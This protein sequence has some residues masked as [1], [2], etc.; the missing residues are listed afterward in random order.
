MAKETRST[1]NNVTVPGLFVV[2][3]DSYKRHP[4]IWKE[5]YN[6]KT[7]DSEYEEGGYISGF[8]HLAAKKE[9]QAFSVASRVQGPVKR[10]VHGTY[11][12]A[13]HVTQELI[14]DAKYGIMKSMM[15][16]LGQTAADTLHYYGARPIMTGTAT[17]YHTAA[18]GLALFSASHTQLLGGTF[19]NLGSAATPTEATLTAAI[20]AF[21]TIRTPSLKPYVRRPKYILCGPTNEFKFVKLLESVY[22]PDTANNAVNAVKSVRPMKLIVDPYITDAR[23]VLIGED[24]TDLGLIHFD[25]IKPT[26]SRHGDPDTGDAVFVVRT[27]FSNECGD[28]RDMY[29]IPAS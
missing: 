23:W 15:K 13:A 8:A 5:Y 24:T 12:L 7:S 3:T 29:M 18:D 4:A 22:E 27:R 21:E 6:I 1:F 20:Q 10:W 19:S 9:G 26:M 2:G 17:T 16:D 11:G 14:E 25:R 28:P